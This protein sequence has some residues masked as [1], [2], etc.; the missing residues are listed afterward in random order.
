MFILDEVR[1]LWR[2]IRRGVF[3]GWPLSGNYLKIKIK[4]KKRI[5]L[6]RRKCSFSFPY[7]YPHVSSFC[8]EMWSELYVLSL[9][10][11]WKFLCMRGSRQWCPNLQQ[12]SRSEFNFWG[13]PVFAAA[14]IW[15]VGCLEWYAKPAAQKDTFLHSPEVERKLLLATVRALKELGHSSYHKSS[16][17]LHQS[18]PFWQQSKVMTCKFLM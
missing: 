13:F 15:S 8:C 6:K 4:Y 1:W 5:F 3:E 16:W 17:S 7:K 11:L 9:R 18:E 2:M 14:Y 12:R 10:Q